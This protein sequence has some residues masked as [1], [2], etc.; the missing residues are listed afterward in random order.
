MLAHAECTGRETHTGNR[1]FVIAIMNP[2]RQKQHSSF[3]KISSQSTW[4]I[5]IVRNDTHVV[6]SLE[7]RFGDRDNGDRVLGDSDRSFV[8]IHPSW[9]L[10][11]HTLGKISALVLHDPAGQP[12]SEVC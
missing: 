4:Q 7:N 11:E 9:H 6:S 8:S 2:R 3:N 1:R 12:A 10:D 5:A